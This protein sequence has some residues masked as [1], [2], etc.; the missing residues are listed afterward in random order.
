MIGLWTAENSR[1]LFNIEQT[2]CQCLLYNQVNMT[3][4]ISALIITENTSYLPQNYNVFHS[5]RSGRFTGAKPIGVAQRVCC[6]VLHKHLRLL[7]LRLLQPSLNDDQFT[8]DLYL[9]S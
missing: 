1:V 5:L 9:N 7:H 6:P 4:N 2:A 8:P 3:G